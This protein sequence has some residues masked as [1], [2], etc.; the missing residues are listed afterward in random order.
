MDLYQ[1]LI[2]LADILKASV[3]IKLKNAKLMA[4]PFISSS[5]LVSLFDPNPISLACDMLLKESLFP[6]ASSI[7]TDFITKRPGIAEN[8]PYLLTLFFGF[9]LSYF[10]ISFFSMM[11]AIAVSAD[12]KLSFKILRC[13]RRPFLTAFYTTV[14]ALGYVYSALYVATPLPVFSDLSNLK[15]AVLFSAAAYIF[16]LYL[17]SVWILSLVVS[18][19]EEDDS[20]G[21]IAAL[22]KSAEIINAHKIHAFFINILVNLICFAVYFGSNLIINVGKHRMI[23][24]VLLVSFSCYMRIFTFVAYTVLYFRAMELR[25]SSDVS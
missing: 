12:Q 1:T 23:Y 10:I 16:Y 22:G 20:A 11:A 24:G 19:V 14:F 18:V 21:G 13:W 8:V 7:T 15:D 5:I 3:K 4:L 6:V 9:F 2:G 17:S 25:L